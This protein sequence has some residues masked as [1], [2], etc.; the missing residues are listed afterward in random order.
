VI[1]GNVAP[2]HIA[3]MLPAEARRKFFAPYADRRLS[4]S[5]FSATFGL[6]VRPSELGLSSYSTFLLPEWMTALADYRRC[7]AILAEPPG[8]AMPPIAVVNYSVIDSGLGGPPYPVSVV[9]VDRTLNWSGLDAAAYEAKRKLWREAIGAA[10]DRVFPGFAAHT[11]ASVFS[12][13]STMSSYLNA[14]EGAVYGFAPLP[15]RGPIWRGPERSPQTAITGLYLASSYA[16][17][18]GYTGAILAGAAA[19]GDV[20]KAQN[21]M[22]WFPAHCALSSST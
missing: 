9:G 11:V 14:P 17:S 12:T 7:A 2:I 13:A 21:R 10:I 16:G 18:G 6:L 15:P 3:D 20:L 4:I 22:R 8:E 19:A 1:V 5:L